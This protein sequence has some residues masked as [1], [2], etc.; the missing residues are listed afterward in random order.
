[1]VYKATLCSEAFIPEKPWHRYL[2]TRTTTAFIRQLIA[3]SYP[4][5]MDTAGKSINFPR[6]RLCC[7]VKALVRA[8]SVAQIA[9][10]SE[11]IFRSNRRMA[12]LPPQRGSSCPALPDA[13]KRFHAEVERSDTVLDMGLAAQTADN[14]LASR[15]SLSRN[16]HAWF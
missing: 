5:T 12:G 9:Q 7:F 8:Q 15:R 11:Q 2:Y 3:L 16:L 13:R 14:C 4:C 6:V 1:M 10:V